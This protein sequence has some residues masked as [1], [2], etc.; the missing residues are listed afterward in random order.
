MRILCTND[1][2]VLSEGLA[3][4][5]RVAARFGEVVTVAPDRERS[6]VSHA[7]TLHRPLRLR[8]I[9]ARGEAR[10][11]FAVDG[12]PCDCVWM[13]MNH[14]RAEAP[15]AVVLSG[16]NLGANLG[17]DILYSGTVSGAMEGAL[18]GLPAMAVSVLGGRRYPFGAI[19]EVLDDLVGRLI[20][21]PPPRGT[22]LNVNFPPAKQAI[23]GVRVT[24]PGLRYYSQEVV[25]RSDP[26]G[27]NYVWIGGGTVTTEDIPGSDCN[28]VAEGYVSVTPIRLSLA[29]EAATAAMAPLW[30]R[31]SEKP[32]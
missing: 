28:A 19:E 29:D 27:H 8:P 5:E 26:R 2:G 6:G 1:D 23:R 21:S 15:P 9:E 22:L 17:H 30:N 16:I 7:I 31:E 4:L 13:G 3:A 18:K 10:E 32:R 25:E 24:T 14:V 20:A 12:T 11:R